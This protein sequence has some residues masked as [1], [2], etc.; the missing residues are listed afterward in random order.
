MKDDMG[1]W[2]YL[3]NWLHVMNYKSDCMLNNMKKIDLIRSIAVK[4]NLKKEQ[5][6]IVVEGVMEAI[7]EALHQGESVTLVGFGTFEVKERKARKGYNLS[8]GEMMT[9]PGKKTVRFKPGA[10]MNLEKK[11]QDTSR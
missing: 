1:Y 6:A 8:T 2:L 3:D 5:I 10:K 4:S 11:H 9:I 7:A